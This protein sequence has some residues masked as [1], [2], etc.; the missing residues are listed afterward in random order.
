M[1]RNSDPEESGEYSKLPGKAVSE[2]L[3]AKAEVER[4]RWAI[5]TLTTM[6]AGYSNNVAKLTQ[7][8]PDKR[9]MGARAAEGAL[10]LLPPVEH[11]T[12]NAKLDGVLASVTEESASLDNG[13][14]H[15]QLL[16]TVRIMAL[17]QL[18]Q[19]GWNARI[20]AEEQAT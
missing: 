5:T 3:A 15:M 7:L 9:I 8:Y 12:R 10:V 2:R 4:T 1:R 13:K 20:C 18:K 19:H 16:G 14:R 6:Y 17:Y 11:L